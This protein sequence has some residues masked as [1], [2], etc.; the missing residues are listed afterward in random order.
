MPETSPFPPNVV[1]Y[2]HKEISRRTEY[3]EEL[4][5]LSVYNGYDDFYRRQYESKKATLENAI[6]NLTT[7]II[8][9]TKKHLSSIE[10]DV[11]DDIT[12]SNV[13]AV[14]PEPEELIVPRIYH[15]MNQGRPINE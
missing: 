11:N 3:Q 7:S 10:V 13:L 5:R 4:E 14:M 1:L 8:A 2:L 6:K 15:T 12:I 9:I